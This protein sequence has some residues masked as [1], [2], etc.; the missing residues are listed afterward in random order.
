LKHPVN[1]SVVW[2]L[3]ILV[4]PFSRLPGSEGRPSF[5]CAV[6]GYTGETLLRASCRSVYPRVSVAR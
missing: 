6:I 4:K 3:V 2:G 1:V 5:S